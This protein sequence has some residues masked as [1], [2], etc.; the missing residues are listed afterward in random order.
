RQIRRLCER[1][2]LPVKKLTRVK[3]GELADP[4]LA[5]G[6]WRR[7]TDREVEY[8]KNSAMGVEKNADS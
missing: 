4:D 5:P 2:S 7:L 3:I 8:L 6:K 1:R